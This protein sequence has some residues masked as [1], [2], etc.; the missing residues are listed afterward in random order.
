M[1]EFQCI[2]CGKCCG[3]IPVS[4]ED[5]EAIRQ[6]VKKMKP[7]ERKRLRRQKRPELVCPLRDVEKMRCAVYES[8]PLLC[9]MFGHYVGLTCPHNRDVAVWSDEAG[10]EK[11]K[12]YVPVG[13]LAQNIGWKELLRK[14]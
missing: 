1:K 5:L 4:I 13:V 11:V 3:A 2:N 10:H 6:A 8:R 9:R 12:G 7:K 14:N